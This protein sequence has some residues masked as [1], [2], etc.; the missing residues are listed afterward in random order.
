MPGLGP[1]LGA[2]LLV[3][4]G[5]L[6]NFPVL[7]TS[8]RAPDWR[9]CPTTPE[10]E[11]ATAQTTSLQPFLAPRVLPIGTDEHD[12]RRTQPHLLLE[13]K[14]S[15]KRTHTPAVTKPGV[16]RQSRGAA[17]RRKWELRVRR[18]LDEMVPAHITA[19]G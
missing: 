1:V 5:E 11:Q 13:K 17:D 6:R 14:R 19:P 15:E 3:S 18:C 4:A 10:A 2:T 7:V 16:V 8:P 12:A 9:P